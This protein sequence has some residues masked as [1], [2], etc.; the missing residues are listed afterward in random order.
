LF[1]IFVTCIRDEY[2]R[3]HHSYTAPLNSMRTSFS[4]LLKMQLFLICFMQ[5][6]SLLWKL[7]L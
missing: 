4:F 7:S 5:V 6:G 3:N 1:I 2:L